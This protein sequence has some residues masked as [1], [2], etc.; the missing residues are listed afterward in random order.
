M[1]RAVGPMGIWVAMDPSMEGAVGLWGYDGA[2]GGMDSQG[3]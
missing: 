1:K 2:Y 3:W